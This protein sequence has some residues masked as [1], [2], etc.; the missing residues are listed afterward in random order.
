MHGLLCR[1]GE[2]G[3]QRFTAGLYKSSAVPGEL[4]STSLSKGC[5]GEL[6][7]TGA[8]KLVCLSPLMV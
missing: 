3:S 1:A 6:D 2:H 8:F 4:I 7:S 5:R